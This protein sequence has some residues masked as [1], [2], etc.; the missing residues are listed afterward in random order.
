MCC[1]PRVMCY[2]ATTGTGRTGDRKNSYPIPRTKRTTAT[3]EQK[4]I[5]EEAKQ[6]E[7]SYGD[8][9]VESLWPTPEDFLYVELRRHHVGD[10]EAERECADGLPS[11]NSV[12]CG[13]FKIGNL[14][15][16][17]QRL[18]NMA[19]TSQ[20]KVGDICP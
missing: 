12:I 13:F 16:I 5:Q 4:R 10:A 7:F 18:G 14:L 3:E 6:F 1:Y 8:K 9:I 19:C 15:Q 2:F 11:A 20:N 17:M